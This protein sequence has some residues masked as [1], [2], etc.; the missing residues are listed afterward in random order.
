[1]KFYTLPAL[2]FTLSSLTSVLSVPAYDHAPTRRKAEAATE[3]IEAPLT[4]RYPGIVST[5]LGK[6]RGGGGGRGGGSSSGSTSS[7]TRGGSG[8]G[9]SSG[10]SSSARGSAVRPSYGGGRFYGGGAA[11]PYRAGRTSPR[12]IVPFAVGAAAAAVI[13]PGIWL[14][15]CY[16][17]PYANRYSFRNGTRQGNS[18]LDRRQDD[19]NVTL[20]VTCLCAQN[21]DCGCDDNL[22]DSSYLDTIVGDGTDLNETLVHI[23]PVNDTE[24]IVLNGTLPDGTT[25]EVPTESS[26]ATGMHVFE[27]SGIWAIGGIVAAAVTF[28]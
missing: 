7:G 8:S 26:A 12:G 9:S 10:G 21:R 28:L 27:A 11:T 4:K 13:F 25:E 17:Y 5:Y 16:Q 22:D 19:G 6:R 23:G 24:T 18:T 14:A 3:L 1:M 20:P 15:G 2:L